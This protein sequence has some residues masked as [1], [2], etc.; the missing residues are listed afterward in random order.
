MENGVKRIYHLLHNE[1]DR[2]KNKDIDLKKIYIQNADGELLP[3]AESVDAEKYEVVE[4]IKKRN[5]KNLNF[6]ML[7]QKSQKWLCKSLSGNAF[8][9]I[10]YFIAEMKFDNAVYGVNYRKIAKEINIS[11]RTVMRAIKELEE[12]GAVVVLGKKGK[13]VYHINPALVW[14]GAFHTIAYKLNMFDD[15]MKINGLWKK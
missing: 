10:C 3:I 4:E 12:I 7:W 9:V 6:V 8:K 11:T 13:K 5:A 15:K 14:K 1:L 2:I